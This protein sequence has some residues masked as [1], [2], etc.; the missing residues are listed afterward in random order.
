MEESKIWTSRFKLKWLLC[1]EDDEDKDDDDTV[2]KPP[3]FF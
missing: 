3:T 2:E 1:A